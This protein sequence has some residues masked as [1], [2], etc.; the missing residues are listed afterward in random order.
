CCCCLAICC[1]FWASFSRR[2]LSSSATE[3]VPLDPLLSFAGAWQKAKP[4]AN[5]RKQRFFL[6][7]IRFLSL[8]A[9]GQHIPQ[10][11]IAHDQVRVLG[12]SH[13]H[14]PRRPGY[15][16]N[17]VDQQHGAVLRVSPEGLRPVNRAFLNG[18]VLIVTRIGETK[19]LEGF[20]DQR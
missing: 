2:A 7:F 6:S 12:R 19:T 17:L 10:A 14:K 1:W 5:K 11:H 16:R 20:D 15:V 4:D 8:A 18:T 9:L 3:G 13:S